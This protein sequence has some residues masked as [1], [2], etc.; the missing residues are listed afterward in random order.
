MASELDLIQGS[1]IEVRSN[2]QEIIITRASEPY[3]LRD[4]VSK[5]SD[6]NRHSE[7]VASP[8]GREVW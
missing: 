6:S 3:S 1:P 5:I 7:I 8:I 2:G 4:L